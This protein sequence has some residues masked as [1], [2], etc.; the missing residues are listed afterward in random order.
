MLVDTGIRTHLEV[1]IIHPETYSSALAIS[2]S[3][4]IVLYR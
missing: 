2:N 4:L 1:N 3:E